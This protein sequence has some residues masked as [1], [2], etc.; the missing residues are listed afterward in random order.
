[1]MTNDFRRGYD[2]RYD[3][4]DSNGYGRWFDPRGF[5]SWAHQ[6][7]GDWMRDMPWMRE[8][9]LRYG[10]L[11]SAPVM[12][13]VDVL[14]QSPHSW[15]DAMRRAIAEASRTISG[16]RTVWMD[17]MHAVMDEQH[18]LTFRIRARICYAMDD[19]RRRR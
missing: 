18:G 13:V 11:E 14:A 10:G 16:I 17:D 1:M 5:G 4:V 15:E 6:S 3:A 8:P 12:N 9:S 19:N 2:D 7:R